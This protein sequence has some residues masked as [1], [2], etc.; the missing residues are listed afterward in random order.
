[1]PKTEIK[2]LKKELD[3]LYRVA[4]TV[5]SLELAEL[6]CEI[7]RIASEVT[8]ADSC[9][10]YVLDPKKGELV[11]RASKNPHPDLIQKITMKVGEGIT[12]WV[13]K[14]QKAVAIPS[15]ANKDS[16]FKLFRSLPEDRF[17]AFLSVPIV[18]KHG[19][20]GVINAQHQKKHV[21]TQMEINLL[22]AIGK[23]VG[24]AVENALLIEE[25]LELKDAL[26]LRKLIEKAKG[27][28]M[29]RRNIAEEEAYTLL[30]KE[31]MNS[32]KTFKEVAE[33]V[34]L[35]QKLGV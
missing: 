11:L 4:Q 14:E 2:L 16:R 7:V 26:E 24:G 27:I 35:A 22:T 28:V 21:H 17:E 31:S 23:L 12:G 6:L 1:M 20:V 15:G 33:A 19:V 13:A 30:Q 3:F 34:I 18:N 9:L 5:H 25:T 29:K 10:V 8:A 32:R